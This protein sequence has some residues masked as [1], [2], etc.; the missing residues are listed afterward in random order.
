VPR[1]LIQLSELAERA[2]KDGRPE[3]IRLSAAML[4]RAISDTAA[5]LAAK[6][7]GDQGKGNTKAVFEAMRRD[8]LED[9]R[10]QK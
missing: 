4:S 8:H 9:T 3:Q 1:S 7:V 2:C 5:V 6:F 10:D